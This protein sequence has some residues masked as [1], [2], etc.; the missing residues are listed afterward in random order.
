MLIDIE[1]FQQQQKQESGVERDASLLTFL[2][3]THVLFYVSTH[4]E[5]TR[6]VR[7]CRWSNQRA[8]E[9]QLAS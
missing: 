6:A 5:F 1:N 2:L 7:A 9:N 4:S 8:R 3:R